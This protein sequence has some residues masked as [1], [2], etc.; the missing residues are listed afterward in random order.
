MCERTSAFLPAY[1]VA[2]MA[3]S[4]IRIA[5]SRTFA[6]MHPTR[7]LI[8]TWFVALLLFAVAGCSDAAEEAPVQE[9]P[10]RPE[11]VHGTAPPAAGG[12]PSVVTLTP[13]GAATQAAPERA[14]P[15][16]D[17]LGLAFTPT[18]LMVRVG[19]TV[20]FTNS[21]TIAH[22]V[23]VA[24]SDNDSTVLHADTDPAGSVD[25]VMEREGGYE[26][27]CELHPG[28][29]A[30]IYVTSAPYAVFAN[31]NGAYRIE[32]VPPGSYELTIWSVDPTRRSERTI[33][34]TGASTEVP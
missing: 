7:T 2:A 19:E 20:T 17:Q 32:N 24:F 14:N 27:T 8:S 12:T 21:E 23:H 4:P 13:A 29:R 15:R 30:A 34:V 22:N 9:A 33:E 31:T 1:T 6:D 28:M 5:T 11:G 26:V 3:D 10:P 18:Q 16:M 25:L